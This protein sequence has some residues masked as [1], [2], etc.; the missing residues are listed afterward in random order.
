MFVLVVT[1]S[2]THTTHHH[3]TTKSVSQLHRVANLR[4]WRHETKGL[5]ISERE[6]KTRQEKRRKAKRK[7]ETKGG[8]K[9]KFKVDIKSRE[10]CN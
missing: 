6:K 4:Q 9:R 3:H 1:Y 7:E 10:L 2:F 8:R 5:I